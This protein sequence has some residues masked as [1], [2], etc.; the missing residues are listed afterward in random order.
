ML[1]SKE[2]MFE[3][4]EGKLSLLLNT[5]LCMLRNTV[6]NNYCVL[7]IIICQLKLVKFQN[8]KNYFQKHAAGFVCSTYSVKKDQKVWKRFTFDYS[9]KTRS[10]LVKKVGLHGKGFIEIQLIYLKFT[11]SKIIITL[12]V[13]ISKKIQ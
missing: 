4:T 8:K 13:I 9:I 7:I 10:L 3:V 6:V 1:R 11:F 5:V 2:V 12:Y